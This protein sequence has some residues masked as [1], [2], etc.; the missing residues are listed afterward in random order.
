MRES[1]PS[2]DD[3][4]KAEAFMSPEQ[5][6]AT[7]IRERFKFQERDAFED[8]LAHIDQDGERRAATESEREQMDENISKLGTLFEGSDLR[9]Q[10]DGALNISLARGEYIGIHKDVDVSIERD[11]LEKIDAQLERK[12]YGLFLSYAADSADP[13]SKKIMERVGARQFSQADE[14]HLL[15]AAIDEQGKIRENETLN[16]IDVHL[17][18]RDAQGSPLGARDVVLP[19]KWY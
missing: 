4:A 11:E 19:E 12:G 15:I 1:M 10:I 14:D 3:I 7:E 5:Q 9:W 13:E 18:K 17:A 2:P 8:F 16:F 6:Q